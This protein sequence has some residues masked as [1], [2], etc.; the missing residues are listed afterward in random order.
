MTGAP[1][2]LGFVPLLDAAPLIVAEALGFAEEEGLSMTLTAA[3]SWSSLRDML[4][5]GQVDAAQML[6]PLPVAMALGLGGG[7]ARIEALSVL[8]AN[9][10]VIGVSDALANRMRAQGYGFD[11][12]DARAA[13]V[14]LHAA[15]DAPLRIGVPFHFSMHAELI[16]YWLSAPEFRFPQPLDIRTVP[17]PRMAEALAAGEIDMFAVGEPWGSV[18][19][20]RGVGSLILPGA[21]VWAFSPEKV[22]AVRAGWAEDNPLLAGGMMRAIWR[23]GR[24]LGDSANRST[25]SEI[26]AG[27][28]RLDVTPEL[29]ERALMGQLVISSRGEERHTPHL[30][31]FFEGS[32]TFPWRS[33]AAWIGARLALRFGLDPVAAAQTARSVFRTD[34]YRLHLRPAGA[35]LPGASEKLEG[36]LAHPTA[37]SSERGRMILA[38]DRFFDARIF[39]PDHPMR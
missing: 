26:L 30:I 22:L 3:P 25:A 13:A 39:D 8:N 38:A 1:I 7:T 20:E 23:A 4:V 33:Q 37:V 29:I 14:A 2:R 10:D 15:S 31:E 27:P 24:W 16:H 11:F 9:G 21:A 6:S 18:A 36:A 35:D 17:P 34:L 32:A 12:S 28:G 19:V 5:L